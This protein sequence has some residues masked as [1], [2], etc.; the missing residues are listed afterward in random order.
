MMGAWGDPTLGPL[1]C[2]ACNEAHPL[3]HAGLCVTCR[4][5]YDQDMAAFEAQCDDQETS[6][7]TSTPSESGTDYLSRV[8]AAELVEYQHWR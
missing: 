5:E 6:T 7:D 3:D 4:E 8:T 1:R 2:F